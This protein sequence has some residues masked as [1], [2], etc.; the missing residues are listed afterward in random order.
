MGVQDEALADQCHLSPS[1]PSAQ[2]PQIMSCQAKNTSKEKHPDRFRALSP[3]VTV[4]LFALVAR[5]TGLCS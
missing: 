2:P 4:K 1:M 5:Y 3:V